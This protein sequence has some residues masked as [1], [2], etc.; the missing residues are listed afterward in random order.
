MV[1]RDGLSNAAV[2]KAAAVAGGWL[3]GLSTRL[4]WPYRSAPESGVKALAFSAREEPPE[5]F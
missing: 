3:P 2:D 4:R 5:L 1:V